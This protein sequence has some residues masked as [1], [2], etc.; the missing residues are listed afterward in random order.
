MERENAFFKSS[1]VDEY[2]LPQMNSEKVFFWVKKSE[3]VGS[4]D[5]QQGIFI[6]NFQLSPDEIRSMF[7][8]F[9]RKFWGFSEKDFGEILNFKLLSEPF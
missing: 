8:I 5:D 6:L 1:L 2:H 9:S 4:W 7:D 3:Y